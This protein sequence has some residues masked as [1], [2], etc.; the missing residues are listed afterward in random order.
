MGKRK[1]IT[2]TEKGNKG[3]KK[4]QA[5]VYPGKYK[6][7]GI[8]Y[9]CYFVRGWKVDGKWQR[10]QFANE[11]EAEAKAAEINVNLH[12]EGEKQALVLTSLTQQQI[13]EA[14]DAFRELKGVY[15]LSEVTEFFL[16]HNRAP[17]F[18]IS[19]LDGMDIYLEQ[20]EHEGVRKKSRDNVKS[21]I[22]TFARATD[23]PN[24]HT[25]TEESVK[26]HLKSLRARDGISRAKRATWNNHRNE[27]CSFFKWAGEKDKTTNRPWLFHNPVE[28]STRYSSKRLAEDRDDICISSLETVRDLMTYAMNYK[29]GKLAKLFALIYFAGLR[30]D[31]EDGEISKLKTG[32]IDLEG[33]RIAVPSDISKTKFERPVTIMPN[34][35]AWLE[36]YADMPIIPVNAKNLYPHVRREFGLQQ[37]ETRHSFISY[38]VA[39]YR[40]LA[41]T[42]LQAGN[43]ESMI[44]RHYLT[45]PTHEEGEQFFSI[46]PDMAKGKAVIKKIKF[47]DAQHLRVI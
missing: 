18:A 1:R 26:H 27:L 12:N 14:E 41:H 9:P 46:V 3:D 10:L 20:K 15:S 38:H 7:R 29:D 17:G 47:E 40:S 25:V 33:G 35:R 44:K 39:L 36:A 37:D 30:P 2:L 45:F 34:L 43:S 28:T 5:K 4:Q 24:V 13:A 6:K 16:K 22:S 32:S 31:Y 21:V 11:Q 8:T 19:L 23:N 42:A